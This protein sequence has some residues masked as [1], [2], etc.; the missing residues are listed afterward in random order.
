M[1]TIII[2]DEE[3]PEVYQVTP[4]DLSSKENNLF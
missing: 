2:P 1:T 4:A 3:G